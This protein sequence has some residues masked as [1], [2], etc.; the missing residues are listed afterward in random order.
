[1]PEQ[2]HDVVLLIEPELLQQAAGY[3]AVRAIEG[4]LHLTFDHAPGGHLVDLILRL[5]GHY[6]THSLLLQQP[7]TSDR[8][9]S[10]ILRALEDC[11]A[12]L[13]PALDDLS[14]GF[15]ERAVDLALSHAEEFRGQTTAWDMARA[16]GVSQRALEYAFRQALDMTPGKYLNQF[17]L[18]S[19]H[20]ELAHAQRGALT[21][22]EVAFSRGFSHLG[23]FSARYRELFGEKP[24]VTLDRPA[25]TPQAT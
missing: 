4:R 3:E 18:N 7:G 22:T 1:M 20:H 16:A 17:R 6:E 21:V 25:F 8:I 5:V 14:P 13:Q 12:D 10:E 19:A 2:A 11:F 24:S 9:R 23:R 15:R